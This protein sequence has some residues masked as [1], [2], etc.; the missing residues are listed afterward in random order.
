MIA[1]SEEDA[2]ILEFNCFITSIDYWFIIL[3]Y[4]YFI[5]EILIIKNLKTVSLKLK[6]ELKH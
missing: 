6:F 3:F 1:W 5:T 2:A 4:N